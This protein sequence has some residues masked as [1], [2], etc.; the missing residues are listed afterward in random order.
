MVGLTLAT[1]VLDELKLPEIGRWDRLDSDGRFIGT[2]RQVRAPAVRLLGQTFSDQT[3]YEFSDADLVGLVG[4]DALP[5]TRF[6]LDY[7]EE[8]LAVTNSP[9]GRA[10]RSRIALPLVRSA[11]HAR[12]ILAEGR[13]N[14]RP[15][16][17]EFD[18]VR[19]ARTS[20]RS[21]FATLRCQ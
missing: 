12:L 10:P 21:W 5:G 11:R 4:P 2:Y 16:L 17:I 8:V 1:Y 18:T 6:T 20:I 7:A 9:L 15:L 3:I 19:A 13:V 14:S